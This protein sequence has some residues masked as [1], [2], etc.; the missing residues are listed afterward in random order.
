MSTP[1]PVRGF[2][3]ASL[4]EL[5]DERLLGLTDPAR[6]ERRDLPEPP[7]EPTEPAPLVEPDP[8]GS[9]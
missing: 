7:I 1:K 8:H 2:Q 9:Y 6:P 5:I 4:D 3:I